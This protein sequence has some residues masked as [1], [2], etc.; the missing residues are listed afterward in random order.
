MAD[1]RLL[2][3][4]ADEDLYRRVLQGDEHA[5]E[6][7]VRRYHGSILGYVYQQTDDRH[8]AEDLVQEIF[9]R[10]VTYGGEPPRH[11]RAWALTI[12]GNL[13]RDHRRSGYYRQEQAVSF[14]ES[15]EPARI[16]DPKDVSERIE[17][18]DERR[19]VQQ[20]LQRL[21]PEQRQVLVLR[22]YHDL[23]LEDIAA[24]M[25]TPLGTVKSRLFHALKQ[26]KAHLGR[27]RERADREEN[28]EEPTPTEYRRRSFGRAAN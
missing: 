18:A 13:V 27:N 17:R 3:E 4:Q 19:E 26:M 2:V 12:A 28:D 8:L 14:D 6:E 11:F 25:N 24:A 21:N 1:D 7:L 5:L 15:I 10:L 9:T 23:K 16:I 22:F 20:A